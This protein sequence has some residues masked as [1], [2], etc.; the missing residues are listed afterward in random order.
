[1]EADMNRWRLATL[2]ALALIL[3]MGTR[4]GGADLPKAT[5]K[6]LAELKLEVSVLDGLDA[7]LNVPKAWLD[8]AAKEDGVTVF[9]T[10]NER[11]FTILTAAFKERY[12]AVNLRYNRTGAAGRTTKVLVAL[13][14]GRVIADVLTSV[15]TA[16]HQFIEMKALADL[17]ELPGFTNLS[18]DFVA[19]DGTWASYRLSFRCIAYNTQKVKKEDLP[20]TWDDLVKSPRWRGGT[21][22]LSNLPEPWLLTLWATKGEAWGTAFT[23]SLFELQPQR[24]KE[25]MNATMA[26]TVA[27]ESDANVPAGE[28]RAR[29]YVKKGAPLGYHCPSPVPITVSQI[30]MLE[31]S[32]HK[33]GARLFIN[34]LLSREGQLVQ[35]ATTFAMPV[36]KALQTPD[37]L[38]FADT[39]TGKPHVVRDDAMLT[40]DTSTRMH[41]V[42][43]VLWVGGAGGEKAAK[44]AS[45]RE[46]SEE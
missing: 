10:W 28:D 14:E 1:M 27:G 36:H 2:T 23:R 11:D 12:P 45:A 42:W 24:R 22:A 33:N 19:A 5:Q 4:A 35:F 29:Q 9:G 37:F 6:A 13:A 44:P 25:G 16:T 43:D 7:E 46:D 39:I 15:G 21:L 34:W 30:G 8:G 40:A 38:M 20:A 3:A 17:R 31:K 32:P 41:E 18:S 26:L